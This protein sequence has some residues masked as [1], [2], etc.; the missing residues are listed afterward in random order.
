M[1]EHVEHLVVTTPD[2]NIIST[3]IQIGDC[4]MPAT[5]QVLMNHLFCNYI[6]WWID[7]YLDDIVVYSDTLEEN[8]EHVRRVLDILK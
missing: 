2:G 1:P 3:V 6:G 4:N 7:V 8:I 5:C